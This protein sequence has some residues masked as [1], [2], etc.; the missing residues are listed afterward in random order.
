MPVS[1]AIEANIAAES[2]TTPAPRSVNPALPSLVP[3]EIS[4]PSRPKP[5]VAA[6]SATKQGNSYPTWKQHK[7]Q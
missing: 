6:G 4:G 2:N 5:T 3:L 1:I 7:Q